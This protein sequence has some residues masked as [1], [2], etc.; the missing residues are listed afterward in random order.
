ME[1]EFG[2]REACARIKALDFT[3]SDVAFDAA[4]VSE[5]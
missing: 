3:A 4:F 1:R 2:A 5:R